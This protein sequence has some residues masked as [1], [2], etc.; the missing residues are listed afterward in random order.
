LFT[1]PMNLL[2]MVG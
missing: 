1:W 2:R